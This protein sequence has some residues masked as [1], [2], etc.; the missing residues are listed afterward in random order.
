MPQLIKDVPVNVPPQ[1]R[2][3]QNVKFELDENLQFVVLAG[4]NKVYL[5]E[6]E[7][8]HEVE[9][10]KLK[11]AKSQDGRFVGIFY[12][13]GRVRYHAS[14]TRQVDGKDVTETVEKF[15]PTPARV[16][17][18]RSVLVGD[19]GDHHPTHAVDGRA[20]NVAFSVDCLRN[21][22]PVLLQEDLPGYRR[23]TC[24]DWNPRA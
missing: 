12:P 15:C 6:P 19:A 2:A 17:P 3:G 21:L 18:Y 7:D 5:A 22:A 11:M 8:P 13:A 24:P 14:V 9:S 10:L 1:F 20:I 4:D 16:V 23:E